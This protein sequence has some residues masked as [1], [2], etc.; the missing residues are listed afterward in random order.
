[1]AEQDLDRG[2]PATPFKLQRAREQ[3]QVAKSQDVVSAVV[4]ATAVTYLSWRGHTELL[5]Q[6]KF[7]FALLVQSSHAAESPAMLWPLIELALRQTGRLMAPFLAT[8][9]LAAALANLAQTG[10]VLST[11]PLKMDFNR[12]NPVNGLKRIFSM[13]TLFDTARALVKL[14]LL[15][16]ISWIALKGLSGQFYL[17]ASLSPRSY[18]DALVSDLSSAGLKIA[19]VLG[20]IALVDFIYSRREFAKKM[21]MSHKEIKDEVKNREGDPRIRSRLREL[22]RDMLKRS[23]AVRQTQKADVLVVNPTH[24][25][26]ALKYE[27]GKMA[28]PQLMAKGVGP[29]AGAMREI[30]ARHQIPIVRN[31]S[32]A[33]RI[34]RAMEINEPVP[35]EL[36]AEVAR[37]I[38]WIFAMRERRAPAP[39]PSGARA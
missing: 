29:M 21:R 33:R 27:H 28:S 8:L 1:M 23:I 14:V 16:T 37:I 2:Q 25:A 35:P 13:R 20:L 6:F 17:L 10:P 24:V 30:A 36:Y 4:F 7:D 15:C 32:L 22:R 12:I 19:L 5:D 26:V 3:G 38:V 31:P 18:L 34:F 9:L 11:T 39:I